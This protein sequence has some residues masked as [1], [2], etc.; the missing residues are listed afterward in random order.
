[1][2]KVQCFACHKFGHYARKCPNKKK[3]Q[4]SASA[5]TE[6]FASKFDREFSLIACLSSCSGTSRVWYIDSGTSAHMSGLREC[7]SELTKRGVDVEVELGDDRV[8]S[9]VG[10]G[11]VAFQRESRPPLRFR[12]VFYVPGLKKNL[13]SVSTIEDKGFEVRF[14]D[15]RVYILPR[16]ASFAST[17]VI[18]T[19]C[20]KLYKLDFRPCQH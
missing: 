18:G 3:K 8:V 10:R 17:K 1:M 7:F 19:W 12:D 20:G 4:D 15:G 13:I 11:T 9:T 5:N 6:E 2:S 16:G 14:R